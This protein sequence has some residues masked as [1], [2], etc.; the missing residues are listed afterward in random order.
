[1]QVEPSKKPAL[2]RFKPTY[3]QPNNEP[4]VVLIDI[5]LD[6]L[7]TKMLTL[8][9]FCQLLLQSRLEDV[10]SNLDIQ[11]T[12]ALLSFGLLEMV[13]RTMSSYVP[14]KTLD[15]IFRAL[16]KISVSKTEAQLVRE[17]LRNVELM[18]TADYEEE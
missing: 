12:E 8:A 4:I 13:S 1:M 17:L 11:R 6:M 2:K 7:A 3:V 15:Y 16:P 9:N 18:V 5:P 14:L 10:Q